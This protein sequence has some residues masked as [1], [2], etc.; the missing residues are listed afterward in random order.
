MDT[1]PCGSVKPRAVVM[2][3]LTETSVGE[4]PLVY[5]KKIKIHIIAVG[6][7]S[8]YFWCAVAILHTVHQKYLK[9]PSTGVL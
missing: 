9:D 3:F 6:V 1:G 7:V 2:S 5:T 4:L 8:K